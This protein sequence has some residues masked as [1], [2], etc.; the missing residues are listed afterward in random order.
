M[1]ILFCGYREWAVE[2][3]QSFS[4]SFD[5]VSSPEELNQ[6]VYHT[7][8]DIIFFIGW[9][10]IVNEELLRSN[11]CICMHPSP[12]PKYRGG[13]PLQNQIIN[14]ETEGAVTLFVMDEQIDHGNILWQKRLSLKGELSSI[15]TDIT[16]LTIQG[17]EFVLTNP[18]DEGYKQDH[19]QATMCKR[20][21]PTDSEIKL[22]DFLVLNAT[23]LYNKI[24]CLQNPYP[25]PFIKCKNGTRLYITRTSDGSY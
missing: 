15:L 24:R 20:R 9:S 12:L 1:K 19:A 10:W 13:S 18:N 5:F 22:E 2:V 11:R 7:Q 23:Q 14:G 17:I 21:K 3:Y 8:Y 25:R 16:A 6:T 4:Q